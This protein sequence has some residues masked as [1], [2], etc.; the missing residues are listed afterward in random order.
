MD[1]QSRTYAKIYYMVKAGML[2][3]CERW[4]RKDLCLD[5]LDGL[6]RVDC[7]LDEIDGLGKVDGGLNEIDDLRTTPR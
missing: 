2:T 7:C 1:G 5:E 6:C 3:R 4:S